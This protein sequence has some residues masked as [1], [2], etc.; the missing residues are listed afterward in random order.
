MT[1]LKSMRDGFGEAL[2]EL[3][4]KNKNVVVLTADLA[5]STRVKE[6]AEKYPGR[7]FQVGVAEQALVTVAAGMAEAGKIPF[8]TSYAVFSPGRT[9]EQIKVTAALSNL[10]IKIIGAH[11]GFGASM[12]GATH[13]S[14][15]DIALMRVIP[16]MITEVPADYYEAKKATFAIAE[17]GKPSYLRLARQNSPVITN[18]NSKFEIGKANILREGRDP[19]VAIIGCGP[20]LS[21]ALVA[22]E[23]L[24]DV[25]IE[26]MVINNHTIKPIDDIAITNAA[27]ICDAI[28][29]VEEHQ[30]MGGLGSAVSE[31][32]VQGHQVPMEFVGVKDSFGESAKTYQELWK[33]FGLTK[34]NI[35]EAVKKVIIRKNS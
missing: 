4:E 33:K 1:D 8:T 32:V 29:T 15:E 12:Y 26:V 30:V 17:N 31:V 3:G 21:E 22:A 20:I 25:G 9:F 19:Q 14:L 35:I 23:E 27:R 6:F 28:V 11:A 24:K 13:Q 2:V 5:D 34:E 7:F 10:P 16:N 18:E